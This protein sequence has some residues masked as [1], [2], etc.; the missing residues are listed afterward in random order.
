MRLRRIVT[1]FPRF[2]KHDGLRKADWRRIPSSAQNFSIS[3]KKPVEEL[4]EIGENWPRSERRPPQRPLYET[5]TP[6]YRE[7]K[8]FEDSDCHPE[9]PKVADTVI[10]VLR[11][12][13]KLVTGSIKRR[14]YGENF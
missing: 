8:A 7:Y 4:V 2:C 13:L 1:A 6:Q 10:E 11:H 9:W 3:L 5:K 12:Y 14:N